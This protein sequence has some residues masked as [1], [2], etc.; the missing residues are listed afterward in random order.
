MTS[1]RRAHELDGVDAHR[2][3]ERVPPGGAADQDD[4]GGVGDQGG[5]VRVQGLDVADPG[6]R[7]DD[8]VE[9]VVMTLRHSSRLTAS[10]AQASPGPR[11]APPRP[12]VAA[13]AAG[14][15]GWPAPRAG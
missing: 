6:M 12:A 4:H 2:Q 9:T 5:Q 10:F 8:R 1:V 11:S 14:A 3:P 7:H 15:A 13:G